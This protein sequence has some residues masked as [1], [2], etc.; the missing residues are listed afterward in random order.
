M[1]GA[2]EGGDL[3]AEVR[4]TPTSPRKVLRTTQLP[5]RS[6]T[7]KVAAPLPRSAHHAV[8][9]ASLVGID[10]INDNLDELSEGEI[11][12]AQEAY[13]Y[14]RAVMAHMAGNSGSTPPPAPSSGKGLSA[15]TR[16]QQQTG[17]GILWSPALSS[18]SF[19]NPS[20]A[21]F[22]SSSR[23]R[24]TSTRNSFSSVAPSSSDADRNS[25]KI[26]P[27]STSNSLKRHD[28]TSQLMSLT[29]LDGDEYGN[30]V[31]VT[32][33][34]ATSSLSS[35]SRAN[36]LKRFNNSTLA[37][38]QYLR[39]G[40]GGESSLLRR[41]ERSSTMPY[42]DGVASNS[43]L[44][45]RLQTRS[46]FSVISSSSNNSTLYL[47]SE[48]PLNIPVELPLKQP[49]RIKRR[50]RS[51]SHLSEY[52]NLPDLINT[53]SLNK[54]RLSKAR[55]TSWQPEF[56][57]IL[58]PPS[59]PQSASRLSRR[60]TDDY[61]QEGLGSRRSKRPPPLPLGR[62][63]QSD[64]LNMA[65]PLQSAASMDQG[66][67]QMMAELGLI[68]PDAQDSAFFRFRNGDSVSNGKRRS[69][70]GNR[71]K[72]IDFALKAMGKFAKRKNSTGT[73]VDSAQQSEALPTPVVPTTAASQQLGVL[74]KKSYTALVNAFFLPTPLDSSSLPIVQAS[75]EQQGDGGDMY[76]TNSPMRG[77][78]STGNGYVAGYGWGGG[79]GG[80]MWGTPGGDGNNNN[81]GGGG[82]KAPNGGPSNGRGSPPIQSIFRRLELVGRGA[83]GAVYRGIHVSS[84][85]VVALKVVNL[86][87]PEDDVS[88]I[89]RE[90]ALLS[91]LQETSTKN[92]VKYWG[93]WLKGSELWIVMDFAEGGS[94]RTLMK[95]G[96]IAE[97][98]AV[99]IVRESLV[100]LSYLHKSGII[101][102]DIKAANILLTLTGKVLLC[103]FGVAAS[104]VSS[105]VHSKRS[106]FVGT[107]YW[108]APEVITQ[109]KTYDQSAD[110]WSLGITI[111]EMVTGNP[112]LSDQE[113]MRAIML[114]PKN[115]PP[116]LPT[117]GNFSP[118]LR[119]FV[120][121]CL[122]E[123]PKERPSA[124]ELAKTKWIKGSAKV[125]N[126]ILRDLI[127]AFTAW[128][129]GGGMRMSLLGA[130]ANE[131][132]E[133][134]NR[135]SLAF[136]EIE[137][138]D[139][140]EFNTVNSRTINWFSEEQQQSLSVAPVRDHPL[141][142]LFHNGSE[143]AV[144]TAQAPI[145]RQANNDTSSGAAQ[146]T[147][148]NNAPQSTYMGADIRPAPLPPGPIP[149][150][151]PLAVLTSAASALDKGSFTGMGVT[152][153]RFGGGGGGAVEASTTIPSPPQRAKEQTDQYGEGSGRISDEN[154]VGEV[155]MNNSTYGFH[156]GAETSSSANTSFSTA[157]HHKELIREDEEDL[158]MLPPRPSFHQRE[159]SGLSA[160]SSTLTDGS[161]VV[162]PIEQ[163]QR[164]SRNSSLS[165]FSHSRDRSES[166]S[167]SASLASEKRNGA[168]LL[169]HQVQLLPSTPLPLH[170]NESGL[171]VSGEGGLN[172]RTPL[173][174][175]S[176][177]TSH[178]QQ[179]LTNQVVRPSQ[180]GV[181]S[182]SGSR[183]RP[184]EGVNMEFDWSN[185][186]HG[187]APYPPLPTRS[188]AMSSQGFVSQSASPK[189]QV[190]DISSA[191]TRRQHGGSDPTT[192][193]LARA[194]R[195]S[196]LHD[197][198]ATPMTNWT[199]SPYPFGA[200]RLRSINMNTLVEKQ[201]VHLEL[202]RT[203][204]DLGKWL[205]VVG[206]R[207]AQIAA[208]CT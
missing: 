8:T 24:S 148:N 61:P 184:M 82:G 136:D 100:A 133:G 177:E 43:S 181:R 85:S 205:D 9:L 29:A 147:N 143:E 71:R 16:Q 97:K 115:K 11:A 3:D 179:H 166:T 103:D 37:A 92:V 173:S 23:P 117:E 93:C 60:A 119:E 41:R 90:V 30:H 188:A 191:H 128:T 89:Q 15:T 192:Q 28:T 165:Q 45:S 134:N 42:A 7:I 202:E 208:K 104:L 150:R 34:R 187:V 17:S 109:G 94:V 26:R 178:R 138:E 46:S 140:W 170:R 56:P 185:Q 175:T 84:G 118:L 96:P 31:M 101:H 146:K 200:P 139:G 194:P 159:R 182:R 51:T 158:A 131:M 157:N 196:S 68:S 32:P 49:K 195:D 47:L 55:P 176:M 102:R 79:G 125:S 10:G 154:I 81:G 54:R 152:P 65:D 69:S 169:S 13:S 20:T 124:D 145:A 48:S 77:G 38:P 58:R 207:L 183:S 193:L 80:G 33:R 197:D 99:V 149:E 73:L 63:S 76:S 40:G 171:Q 163:K 75:G 5:S 106:T 126:S 21:S 4:T 59:R 156:Q 87:T 162:D 135:D 172:Q 64:H 164:H 83:Y 88:D 98:Y 14:T 174:S 190:D 72:S 180:K 167:V 120:S 206:S 137:N 107:P 130:E 22:S 27:S 116:R 203:I 70:L 66:E 122:N 121:I 168:A 44:S 6:N 113:Q 78:N 153:F 141:L 112:P 160:V 50:A 1:S 39:S 18:S 91:Q 123:E 161:K 62:A 36:H 2:N 57:S 204:E 129:K 12:Q 52:I 198:A 199:L 189:I 151:P 35:G 53:S 86:D 144:N 132:N 142:R 95:A 201:D 127:S 186:G 111:Y 110:I 67:M 19:F 108:M 105:S 74:A 114:I 25:W 155:S